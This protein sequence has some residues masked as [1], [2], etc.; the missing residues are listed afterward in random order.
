MIYSDNGTN[1]TVGEKELRLAIEAMK[2]NDVIE[3]SSNLG[4][5][6]RFSPQSGPHFGGVWERPVQSA[7]RALYAVLEDR[8]T[9]DETLFTL[10]TEV[11]AFLNTRP[12]THVSTD[13]ADREPITP[14]NFLLGRAAPNIPPDISWKESQRLGKVGEP[15]NNSWMKFGEAGCANICPGLSRATSGL[16]QWNHWRR[17]IRRSS[18]TTVLNQIRCSVNPRGPYVRKDDT[19]L[20]R[21]ETRT[22]LRFRQTKTDLHSYRYSMVTLW[23]QTVGANRSIFWWNIT[24][25][26]RSQSKQ[27]TV[28]VQG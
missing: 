11:E 22:R 28:W 6:W 12:L 16:S 17:T 5:D 21:H 27:I 3:K 25:G 23:V 9:T 2:Q 7:K 19:V 15:L 18:L 10:L 20:P 13:P 24:S 1:L 14:N 4:T 8:T 26:I